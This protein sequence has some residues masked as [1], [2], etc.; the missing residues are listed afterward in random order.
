VVDK[1][2]L[3]VRLI[4]DVAPEGVA[5]ASLAHR[6]EEVAARLAGISDEVVLPASQVAE[7][8]SSAEVERL[9]RHALCSDKARNSGRRVCPVVIRHIGVARHGD[10]LD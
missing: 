6:S 1:A 7:H 5:H 8:H 2:C 9:G 3:A 4:R 10:D